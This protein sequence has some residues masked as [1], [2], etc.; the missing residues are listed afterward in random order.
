MFEEGM[1]NR[2]TLFRPGCFS[3]NDATYPVLCELGWEAVPS[4]HDAVVRHYTELHRGSAL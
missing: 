1:R 2:P 4:T 3:A